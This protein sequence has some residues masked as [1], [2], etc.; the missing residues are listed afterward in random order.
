MTKMGQSEKQLN[1]VKLT[2]Y[3][4][5]LDMEH[6]SKR[7]RYLHSTVLLK[8]LLHFEI[9]QAEALII[10]SQ[11]ERKKDARGEMMFYK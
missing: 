7:G 4:E 1:S 10:L 3:C 2:Y 11:I 5:L 9:P 6:S 8:Y